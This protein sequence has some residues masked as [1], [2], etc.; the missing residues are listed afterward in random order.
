MVVGAVDNSGKVYE[1]SNTADYVR[2]HAPGVEIPVIDHK[3]NT[4]KVTGTSYCM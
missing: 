3:G 1:N 2:L 4:V